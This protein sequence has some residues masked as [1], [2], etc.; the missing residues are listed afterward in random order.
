MADSK[1]LR[2]FG[3]KDGGMLSCLLDE[4][5]GQ[6]EEKGGSCSIA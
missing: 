1:T 5:Y 4:G 3:I 6:E 2:E